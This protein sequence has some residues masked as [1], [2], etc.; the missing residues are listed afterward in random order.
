MRIHFRFLLLKFHDAFVQFH[1]ILDISASPRY[2]LIKFIPFIIFISLLIFEKN[3]K[4]TL[5]GYLISLWFIVPTLVYTFYGGVTSEY[6]VIL[7]A[8]Q[9]FYILLFIQ[10]KFLRVKPKK[11]MVIIV[12][13]VWGLYVYSNTKK[14]WIKPAYG[15]LHKQ[16]DEVK[17]RIDEGGEKIE[18]NEGVISSYLYHIW[19]VDT[20]LTK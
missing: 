2:S 3:R 1:K 20:R 11:L 12:I 4:Q 10:E 19:A 8:P 7:N 15:G 5:L 17:K 13:I 9:V 14:E 16:E 18:Y 6:Y